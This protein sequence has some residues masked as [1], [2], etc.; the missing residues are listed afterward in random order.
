MK[1]G[2]SRESRAVQR[3]CGR[4]ACGSGASGRNSHRTPT[5]A[6]DFFTDFVVTA[7]FAFV[8]PF[9]RPRFLGG[10]VATALGA[11]AP[12][13]LFFD[14]TGRPRFFGFPADVALLAGLFFDPFGR[15]R[16]FGLPAFALLPPTLL[17]LFVEPFGRPRPRGRSAGVC[18]LIPLPTLRFVLSFD[19]FGRPLPFLRFDPS[20]DPFGRPRPSALTIVEECGGRLRVQWWGCGG[21][22]CGWWR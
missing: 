11:E 5:F 12:F 18:P 10:P 8:D 4:V 6:E 17:A 2:G 19:P 13:A 21:M 1:A 3:A 20:D 22:R 14:P 9:G 7:F 15:P 16:F